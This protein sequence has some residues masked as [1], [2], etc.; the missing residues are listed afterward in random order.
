M[1]RWSSRVS[2]CLSTRP[3]LVALSAGAGKRTVSL[4]K[5]TSRSQLDRDMAAVRATTHMYASNSARSTG[6]TFKTSIF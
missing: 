4:R 6:S 1:A 5:D 3:P 2:R